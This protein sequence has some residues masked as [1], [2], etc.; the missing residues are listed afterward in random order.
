M[1]KPEEDEELKWVII[2]PEEAGG[3]SESSC[4][5][6]PLLYISTANNIISS[7]NCFTK[8]AESLKGI[9]CTLHG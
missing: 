4:T 9:Y 7:L 5:N 6:Q 3:C 2:I 8:W 1:I